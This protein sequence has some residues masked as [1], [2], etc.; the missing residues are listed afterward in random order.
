MNVEQFDIKTG[1]NDNYFD[2]EVRISS[3]HVSKS[4]KF[5]SKDRNVNLG[6][7]LVA[8][9]YKEKGI[10]ITDEDIDNLI[11]EKYPEYFI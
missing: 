3:I 5:Y 4:D 9:Y 1:Y 6:K 10:P 2:I 7:M 8:D 11:K